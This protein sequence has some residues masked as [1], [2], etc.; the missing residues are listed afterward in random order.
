MVIR[1]IKISKDKNEIACTICLDKACHRRTRKKKKEKR[2]KSEAYQHSQKK[3]PCN[4][5][6]LDGS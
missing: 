5:S 2:T 3:S 6:G 4:E 1:L